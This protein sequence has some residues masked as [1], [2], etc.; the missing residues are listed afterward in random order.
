M[1][2]A[3]L[4][5]TQERRAGSPTNV[6]GPT[7]EAIRPKKASAEKASAE[8]PRRETKGLTV[9]C[10]AGKCFLGSRPVRAV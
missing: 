3:E 8:K 4:R 7:N 1:G 9:S 10:G 5:H 2:E 6:L